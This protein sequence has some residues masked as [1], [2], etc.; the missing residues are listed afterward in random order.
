MQPGWKERTAQFWA[1]NRRLVW[2]F[3]V[4]GA[5][6]GLIGA[7]GALAVVEFGLYDIAA[8]QPHNRIVSWALHETFKQS[9][10]LRAGGVSVPSFTQARIISGFRLYQTDCMTCHGGP[11]VA[12]ADWVK[13]LEPTPPFLLESGNEWTPAE[14]DYILENGI[15]MSAMPSWG[16]T[17][18][19]DQIWSLVA[20]L[21]ALPRI[22][23]AQ[24]AEMQRQFPPANA[25]V[26]P[27]QSH[28]QGAAGEGGGPIPG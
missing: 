28:Q 15:K 9:V 4:G 5:A 27:V 7:L 26:A 13:G 12:R 2:A 24:F 19:R 25:P 20:F 16:E 18:S 17:R 11:G 6:A 10:R 1:H 14:L 23:P 21:Q 3:L 8:S 22:S